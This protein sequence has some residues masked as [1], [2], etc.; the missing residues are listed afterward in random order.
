LPV[1]RIMQFYQ[2]RLARQL[3]EQFYSCCMMSL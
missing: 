1:E 3:R 2:Q